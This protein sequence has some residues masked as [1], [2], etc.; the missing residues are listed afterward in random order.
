MAEQR[1]LVITGGRAPAVPFSI[2]CRNEWCVVA[3]DS[4]VDLLSKLEIEPDAI[5]GDM[6]SISD[7]GKIHEFPRATVERYP[8]EKDYTDTEIAYRYLRAAG[9]RDITIL[10]GGGGRLDH[11]L[12]IVSLFDREDHPTRWLTHREEVFSIDN[13]IVVE[14]GVGETISLLPVGLNRCRMKSEG[15][16]WPLD[17]IVWKK[18]DIGISNESTDRRCRVKMIEGRLILV[19]A[20][21]NE[22]ILV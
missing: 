2:G 22:I 8:R 7:A 13:E 11:L 17:G 5:V 3:A 1:G 18:G 15:L 19:R 9:V 12:G 10:G 20:L 21:P 16:K 6:D 4:G 14:C